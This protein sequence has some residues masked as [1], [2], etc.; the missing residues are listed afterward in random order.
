M[1]K[2]ELEDIK[3]LLDEKYAR[4]EA[5]F[6]SGDLRGAAQELYTQDAYYLTARLQVLEGRRAIGDF[7]DRIKA[8]IGEVKVHPL[9][10]WGDPARVVYQLCNTVRRA[11]GGG[12]VSHAHY[13]AA[14]RQ[15]GDDW[16]CEMEVVAPGHIDA[17]TASKHAAAPGAA[18]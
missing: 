15:V 4:G 3:R 18:V 8:E 10:L 11:P 5:L 6:R 12:D 16:L 13:V 17:I 1:R 9:C 14:F 2:F 7:F